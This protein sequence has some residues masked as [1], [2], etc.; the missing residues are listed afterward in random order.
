MPILLD[1]DGIPFNKGINIQDMIDNL[2]AGLDRAVLDVIKFHEGRENA[3]SRELLVH[4]LK[5]MGFD[6]SEREARACINQL[7]KSGMPGTWICSTG[8]VDG[9]YWLAADHEELEEF[10]QK[11]VDARALDLHEQASAMRRAAEKRWGRYSPEKQ[12]SMF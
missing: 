11:E 8:G 3:I 4:D 1:G 2:P 9:G 10:L 12:I 6:V 5:S 7:R